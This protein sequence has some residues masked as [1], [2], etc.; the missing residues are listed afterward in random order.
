ME[1]ECPNKVRLPPAR[2]VG[3]KGWEL[4]SQGYLP[5]GGIFVRQSCVPV[6]SE[7]EWERWRSAEKQKLSKSSHWE[8]GEQWWNMVDC[9]VLPFNV[10]IIYCV[11]NR[12][13]N[14]FPHVENLLSR[15]HIHLA[16]LVSHLSGQL[17]SE[18]KET[19]IVWMWTCFNWVLQ[20]GA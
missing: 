3:R 17:S 11:H 5:Q 4:G 13:S 16:S 12:L 1:N 2:K 14:S 7:N 9:S 20:V 6:Y 18:L 19:T 10:N 8:V 15:Q